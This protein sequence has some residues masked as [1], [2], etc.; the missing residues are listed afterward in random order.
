MS[1]FL[2]HFTDTHGTVTITTSHYPR[3]GILP[4]LTVHVWIQCILQAHPAQ[5][6]H[7]H[8]PDTTR[9]PN[10]AS[11]T[12]QGSGCAPQGHSAQ[13]PQKLEDNIKKKAETLTNTYHA[14]ENTCSKTSEKKTT[15]TQENTCNTTNS[16]QTSVGGSP[17]KPCA[18]LPLNFLRWE[19]QCLQWR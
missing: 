17:K 10:A 9:R 18:A 1:R 14:P 7:A 6:Y 2:I 13:R 15:T 11:W 3:L 12:V 19:R 8:A 4:T 5:A 16:E